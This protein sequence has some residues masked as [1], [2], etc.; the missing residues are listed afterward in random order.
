MREMGYLRNDKIYTGNTRLKKSRKVGQK[1]TP[2]EISGDLFITGGARNLLP[3]A[4][5]KPAP[6]TRTKGLKTRKNREFLQKMVFF[7]QFYTTHDRTH[8]QIFGIFT[9]FHTKIPYKNNRVFF[10]LCQG[11]ISE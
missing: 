10:G 3:L 8:P 6:N 1:Q 9:L 11:I 2:Q 5:E 4:Y 7:R